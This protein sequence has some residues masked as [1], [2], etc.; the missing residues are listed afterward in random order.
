MGKPRL[1]RKLASAHQFGVVQGGALEV[2]GVQAAVGVDHLNAE[3]REQVEED[4]AADDAEVHGEV[5][6]DRL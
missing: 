1:Y 4:G 2:G 3:R 5:V 6:E